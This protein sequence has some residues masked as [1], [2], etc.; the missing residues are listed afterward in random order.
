MAH[1]YEAEHKWLLE[2]QR[3][4]KTTNSQKCLNTTHLFEQ[5]N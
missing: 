5:T 2:K 3:M 1:C 4:E